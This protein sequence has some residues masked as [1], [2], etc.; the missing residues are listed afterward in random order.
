MFYDSVQ[1]NV[2]REPSEKKEVYK[3]PVSVNYSSKF[4]FITLSF[5]MTRLYLESL[6]QSKGKNYKE[7]LKS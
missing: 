2:T 4:A 6:L 7:R 3:L 5:M 1:H